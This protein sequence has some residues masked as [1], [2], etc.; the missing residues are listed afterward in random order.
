MITKELIEEINTLARKQRTVGLSPE[1][2]E[3]Q[4]TLRQA[5]LVSFRENMKSVLDNIEIVD[6]LP[7]NKMN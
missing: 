7:K 4:Q 3:R 1:E 2:K 6:E 5:Y